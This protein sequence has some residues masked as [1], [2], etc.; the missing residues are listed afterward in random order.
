[1]STELLVLALLSTGTVWKRL[2]TTQLQL[3]HTF[4]MW[5]LPGE[6]GRN[7][8]PFVCCYNPCGHSGFLRRRK[9]GVKNHF[10]YDPSDKLQNN[11]DKDSTYN[12]L[13]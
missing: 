13:I 1:M 10:E 7:G 12:E 4:E 11:F 9:S 6:Q 2:S 8:L 5:G 3:I